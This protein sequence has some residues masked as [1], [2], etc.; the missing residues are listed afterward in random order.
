MKPIKNS[1]N[2]MIITTI[3]SIIIYL[4][5]VCY[6][7]YKWQAAAASI[8]EQDPIWQLV[9]PFMYIPF[10]ALIFWILDWWKSYWWYI[11]ILV[12]IVS[13]IIGIVSNAWWIFNIPKYFFSDVIYFIIPALILALIWIWFSKILKVIVNAILKRIP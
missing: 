11:L 6:I 1:K 8:K 7:S 10:I 5:L 3:I 4:L 9:Y 2:L 13:P 12:A